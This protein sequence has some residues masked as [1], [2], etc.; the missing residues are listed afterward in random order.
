VSEEPEVLEERRGADGQ[1]VWVTLNRPQARNALTFAMYE[2]IYEIAREIDADPAVRCA[3]I[4]GAGGR[5]FAAGTDISQFRAFEREQDALDYEA[6]MDRVLGAWE[7]VRVPTIAAIGG[8]CTGGGAG[9]AGACDLRIAT[10]SL[11]FGF[12]IARTLGNTLSMS[13]FARLTSLIGMARVKE[14]I[15][16]ARLVEAEEARAIGLVSEVVASEEALQ[17]R[18]LE[19]AELLCSH[20]PLTL[21]TAKEALRRIREQLVPADGGSDLVIRAYMSA[22]FKEGIE[23]FF[24]KRPAR[25]RG[26]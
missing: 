10:P 5:A 11:R 8:A 18:A 1:I 13:N 19:L 20:A 22:D 3:V 17:P 16:T 6:R 21:Q 25:W 15:F 9:I 14:L 26:R 2:R 7:Q 24:E 4:T 23:A 12:P